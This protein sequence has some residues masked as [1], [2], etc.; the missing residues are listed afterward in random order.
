MEPQNVLSDKHRKLVRSLHL[1][2]NRDE[3]NLF[4]AEGE[5]IV[6]EVLRSTYQCQFVVVQD[7]QQLRFTPL[8]KDCQRRDVPVYS[9]G[10]HAFKLLSD[11]NS[12]QGILAVV[13]QAPDAELPAGNLVALD[14][15]QDPGNVGTIIRTA[16]FFGFSGILLGSKTVD[17]YNPKLIRSTMG[18]IF[19]IP[20]FAVEL[21]QTL[22][23]LRP[24]YTVY[25][26][27]AHAQLRMSECGVKDPLCL[28]VGSEAAGI[29]PAVSHQ[30]DH[31]FRIPSVGSAESLNAAIAAGICLYHFSSTAQ[32]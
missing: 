16:H 25:G 23:L 9:C 1:R 6:D 24:K 31:S 32:S 8:L 28:V 11:T 12:P 10:E 29:S 17:R 19:H 2:K 7:D 30:L 15:I 3:E 26:A 4:I 21:P 14:G 13:S 5:L 27:A 20:V 18:S 22:A